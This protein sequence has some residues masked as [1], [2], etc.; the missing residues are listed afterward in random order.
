MIF[1]LVFHNVALEGMVNKLKGKQVS[2]QLAK[3]FQFTLGLDDNDVPA[4]QT[5]LGIISEKW[6]LKKTAA[7][8]PEALVEALV[9]TPGLGRFAS[10]IGCMFNIEYVCIASPGKPTYNLSG[11]S[12]HAGPNNPHEARAWFS[13]L[14]DKWWDVASWLGYTKDDIEVVESEMDKNPESQIRKFL[15]IFQMPDCGARTMPVLHKLGDLSGV[16]EVRKKPVHYSMHPG[17]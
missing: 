9:L 15:E 13:S 17:N 5:D 14:Q 3:E 2:P 4:G 16:D 12:L 1:I 10:G 11:I 6:I 8:S 7:C